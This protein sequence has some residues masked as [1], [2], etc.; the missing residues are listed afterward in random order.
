MYFP[1]AENIYNLY[2]EMFIKTCILENDQ[3]PFELNLN[4]TM[5]IS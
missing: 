1:V 4:E 3:S 5:S 2:C